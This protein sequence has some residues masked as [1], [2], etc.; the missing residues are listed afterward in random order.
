MLFLK[1]QR[2]I[3]EI[4]KI[5]A[6][7]EGGVLFHCTAGKDRTGVIAALLLGICEVSENDII[8]NY[9]VTNTYIQDVE[10]A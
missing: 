6:N 1:N 10:F 7:A 5:L 2:R 3:Q 8:A 4:F 9:E